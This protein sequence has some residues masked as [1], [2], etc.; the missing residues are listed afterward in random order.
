MKTQ[1]LRVQCSVFGVR[2]NLS[3]PFTMLAPE[4]RN[5]KPETCYAQGEFD[6]RNCP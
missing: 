4:T 2:A 3:K 1:V 6:V 5:L